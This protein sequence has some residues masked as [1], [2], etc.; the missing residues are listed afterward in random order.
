MS[1]IIFQNIEKYGFSVVIAVLLLVYMK[2][3]I[4]STMEKSD[5]LNATLVSMLKQGIDELNVSLQEIK[6]MAGKTM[7]SK[8]QCLMILDDKFTVHVEKKQEIL[9]DILN[10]NDIKNPIRQT[11]IRSRI[12]T[13][14][15]EITRKE[16][17]ELDMFNT[18]IG[19][20]G[21]IVAEMIDWQR[22]IK[23]ITDIIYVDGTKENKLR[24]TEVLM[25]GYISGIK[26]AIDIQLTEA[27]TRVK[28]TIF[29]G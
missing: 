23:E 25:A 8:D 17:L 7:L 19:P 6:H 24:D 29:G 9:R 26:G 14:F 4:K 16:C 22:F 2:A 27:D 12:E 18:K 3:L 5:K 28:S 1:S 13:E 20:V 15:K 21:K 10:K 11:Q